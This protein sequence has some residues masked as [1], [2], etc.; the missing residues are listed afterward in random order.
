MA[1]D[2]YAPCPC[3]SGKKL[4]FC[5]QNLAEDM[6]RISRLIENNQPRQALQ[7]LE[8]LEKKSPGHHWVVTTRALVLLEIGDTL[9]AR[10][11][12]K[13]FLE[14]HPENEF[15]TVLYATSVFQTEG[16]DASRA[17]IA[18]A[19]QKGARKHPSMVSGL[20]AAMATVFRARG[21]LLAARE[22]LALSLRFAPENQRQEIFVRLLD[23]DNDATLPYLLRSAHPLPA[24][25]GDDA[26]TAEVRKAHKYATVGC[27]RTSAETF[28]KLAEQLPQ[29]PE[30]WHAIGLCHAWDGS[31]AVA[32]KALH[33]AAELYADL[34]I[35][36]ECEAIAQ[37]LDW[38][39][40][41]ERAI[42]MEMAGEISS[43]GRLLTALDA[44]PRLQRV[45]LPPQDPNG[46]PL[47]TAVY[48]VLNLTAEEF[49]AADQLSIDNVP[50]SFAEVVV[51]DADPQVNDPAEI[52]VTGFDDS[53]F[54][55]A[56][57]LVRE[58]SGELVSWKDKEPTGE[59]V[60]RDI[61][62][63]TMNWWFPTK[64]P[65][66][67]R[68]QLE[69]QRWHNAVH[70]IWM[71]APLPTLNGQSPASAATQPEQRVRLLAAIY[72][73]DAVCLRSGY[74][75][76]LGEVLQSL[77]VEGLPPAE[78]TPETHLNALSPL[79][80]LRLPLASLTDEQL[81]AVVNRAQLIHHDRFLYEALKAVVQ[82]PACL[83]ELDV[84]R[85]YQTLADLC[86]VHER[87]EEAFHWFAEG[88]QY[89][90]QNNH[91]FEQVWSWDLREL[92]MR[93]EEP[94]DPGLASLAQKFVNYYGPKLPQMRPYVEQ[95]FSLAGAPS[96]WSTSSIITPDSMPNPSGGLWTP[97]S[98][99]DPAPATGGGSG[100]WVPG[101]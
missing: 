6:D 1:L 73:L 58:A 79:Q 74:E 96:P 2:V 16:L 10:D 37:I 30:V 24:V 9:A 8:V 28:E 17:A 7:Q 72:V 64:T 44:A 89:G 39:A 4:K 75:L 23:F 84:M 77:N 36:V 56:C 62:N 29:S 76:N 87:R 70:Q 42:R 12:L 13:Q 92:L 31:D 99:G 54:D 43:V 26:V 51:F 20:A 14:Q 65:V 45:E 34:P 22:H 52:D 68:R 50:R 32:S 78:V 3:G 47:P 101:M 5:C 57:R 63:L 80:W 100:L 38:S 35:A 59:F 93:L 95:M 91:N 69:H 71:N 55:E 83:S 82:R 49:P 11:L 98:P 67:R 15:A 18:R 66:A 46:P 81:T 40:A 53:Q 60:P 97:D 90:S 86:R 48:Q 88:R 85:I 21:L 61:A 27:W 25:V 19:F 41:T 94:N 33:K